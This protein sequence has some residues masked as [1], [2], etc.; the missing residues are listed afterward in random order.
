MLVGR[1]RE[2]GQL[3]ALVTGLTRRGG[4][5]AITGDPGSG[6]TTMLN[7]VAHLAEEAGHTVV[8]FPDRPAIDRRH[9]TVVL[10]DNPGRLAEPDR[11]A[12]AGL[13]RRARTAPLLVVTAGSPADETVTWAATSVPLG[14]LPPEAA[15]ALLA[16]LPRETAR[17]IAEKA[18]GN[19]LALTELALTELALTGE[20]LAL[21]DRLRASLLAEVPE[22]ARPLLAL[23]ACG[24]H[25]ELPELAAAALR[26]G[27]DLGGLGPAERAG[28]VTVIGDTVRVRLPL[29]RE[30]LYEAAAPAERRA[31]HEALAATTLDD[32]AA[33]WHRSVA[34]H[35]TGADDGDLEVAAGRAAAR[36]SLAS[37]VRLLRRAAALAAGSRARGRCL[38]QAAELARQAGETS[39]ARA[40]AEQ[41]VAASPPAAVRERIELTLAELRLGAGVSEAVLGE[42]LSDP[43]PTAAA[44]A[45]DHELPPAERAAL[46][47][48]LPAD[49]MSRAWIDPLAVPEPVRRRP[50]RTVAEFR[51]RTSNGRTGDGR[52]VHELTAA[53]R[54]AGALHDVRTAAQCWDLLADPSLAAPG[55]TADEAARLAGGGV[56]RV[57]TGRLHDAVPRSGRAARL[58][59]RAGLPALGD[60]ATAGRAL[61]EAWTSTARTPALLVNQAPTAAAR[62]IQR[63]A[64]G[65]VALRERRYDQAWEALHAVGVHR[66]T[67]WNAVADLAEAAVG[68]GRPGA[69]AL[70]DQ[71][72]A[73]VAHA[74]RVLDSDHLRAVA[75]RGRALLD[76]RGAEPHYRDS[77]AAGRRAGTPLELARTLLAYGHWL[78]RRGRVVAAREHLGEARFVFQRAG[79]RPWAELAAAE[80]R[81]AGVAS[82][83]R[84][85]VVAGDG[86]L[87]PQELRIA[88]LAAEGMTNKEIAARLQCAPRT[89]AAYLRAVFPKLSVTRRS[90]LRERLGEV[91]PYVHSTYDDGPLPSEARPRGSFEPR[92][93]ARRGRTMRDT[94]SW[95]DSGLLGRDGA[96]EPV[97]RVLAAGRGATVA[98]VADSGLGT[99][100]FLTAVAR[101]AVAKGFRVLRTAGHRDEKDYE[102]AALQAL[103]CPRRGLPGPDPLAGAESLLSAG[104]GP[105]LV[106]VDDLHECDE[107]SSRV[108]RELT[109][110][111][112]DRPVVFLFGVRRRHAPRLVPAG[113]HVV[114]LEPLSKAD[115]A[116]LLARQPDA[117]GSLS[118]LALLSRA[119]GKPRAVVELAAAFAG[120]SA[121]EV[122]RPPVALI[123]PLRQRFAARFAALKPETL[124]LARH[125]SARLA[126]EDVP[127]VLAAAGTSRAALDDAVEAEILETD[128]AQVRFADPLAQVAVYFSCP[129]GERAELHR[130]LAGALP[131]HARAPHLAAAAT[132]PDEQ[133]A[134]GLERA[135][136]EALRS[137]RRTEHA[138]ALAWAADLSPAGHDAARRYADA[139]VGASWLGQTRWALDLHAAAAAQGHPEAVSEE[140][141]V[142]TVLALCRGGHQREAMD[143]LLLNARKHPAR[144]EAL[145]TAA[146]FIAQLSGLEQHRALVRDLGPVPAPSDAEPVVDRRSA[147]RALRRAETAELADDTATAIALRQGLLDWLRGFEGAAGLAE[148][149][150]PLTGALI[151]AGRWAEADAVLDEARELCDGADLPLLEAEV[152]ALRAVLAGRRGDAGAA[153]ELLRTLPHRIDLR[154]NGR[155]AKWVQQALGVAAFA[156]GDH[157]QAYW[158]LR[159]LFQAD[160]RP[161]YPDPSGSALLSYAM[162]AVWTGRT[163]EAA[164]ALEACE[165]PDG[166]RR[167]LVR[168]HVR[169][170]VGTDGDSFHAAVEDPAGEAWPYERALANV[171]YGTWLRRERRVREARRHLTAAL[172]ALEEM[173]AAGMA[174]V[175]RTELRAAGG[176]VAEPELPEPAAAK[177]STLSPQQRHVVLLAARGMPNREIATRLRLSPRTVGTHL[178]NAY[179]KLGVGGRRELGGVLAAGH[180]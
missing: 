169:A 159:T 29:V 2:S 14:P 152:I 97:T 151:D 61:A 55:A 7:H 118:R 33:A 4:A 79:A 67:A 5:V 167:T 16:A 41:A 31:A 139:A 180:Q 99:S 125:V 77:L 58:A 101:A 52:A 171:Q 40:L 28:V 174:E 111:R 179:P 140:A 107:L 138:L 43:S 26:L 90:L 62:A 74:A 105:L 108:L 34:A 44:L 93:P 160:G 158:H 57:L 103:L 96:W 142:E 51:D 71:R 60:L 78:R 85:D 73:E 165:G 10:A 128:G 102:G 24:E 22:D 121:T 177:L 119:Q 130:R 172:T 127:V 94:G 122:L 156:D 178:Y 109:R 65:L 112:F 133:I 12:L 89:V 173:G 70:A 83:A 143:Q 25:H 161:R 45:H 6:R 106:V 131:P 66:D 15:D 11:E 84:E 35:D 64:L 92:R 175:A 3:A 117:G 110:R 135:G 145:V 155:L 53:A 95:P 163:A 150:L 157:E 113:A 124:L 100:A 37:A 146:A 168:A 49:A 80:L 38:A 36:G 39:Q 132:G 176:A 81:A 129:A 8:R 162:A 116:R 148:L 170:L 9:P 136:A 30:A 21:T 115:A 120:A 166:P 56:T 47:R 86:V 63:W 69:V 154:E 48:A 149:C 59:A 123:E 13:A 17:R 23:L 164:R 42:L 72:V 1:E 54:A 87:S 18:R 82:G 46:L 114:D 19:P 137:G 104:A 75:S 68:S 32:A 141:A 98:V 50:A 20:P 147:L 91:P 153:R 144:P 76:E 134:A 88:R 126:D 27:L